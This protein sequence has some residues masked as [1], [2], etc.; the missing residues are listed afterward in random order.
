LIAFSGIESR[1][2]ASLNILLVE[3]EAIVAM[4]TQDALEELGCRVVGWATTAT[5]AEQLAARHAPDVILMDIRIKGGID[6]IEAAA[7]LRTWST[8]PIVFVSGLLDDGMRERIRLTP[9]S[10]ILRKP[11]SREELRSALVWACGQAGLQG[12][13][14]SDFAGRLS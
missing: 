11:Y 2:T 10:A 5:D 13:A 9:S 1:P 4:D 8:A 6:G 12:R 7:R 3:D 14:S